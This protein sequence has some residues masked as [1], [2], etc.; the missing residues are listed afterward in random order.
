MP[1]CPI[2]VTHRFSTTDAQ[3]PSYAVGAP[4]EHPNELQRVR[5]E[6][7]Q[8][9]VK[10][11]TPEFLKTYAPDSFA[12]IMAKYG[13]YGASLDKVGIRGELLKTIGN[14]MFTTFPAIRDVIYNYIN[15]SWA[16]F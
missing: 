7:A 12:R 8:Q 14:H 9:G 3:R 13:E 15:K 6:I 4:I 1:C 5:K 10:K 16:N 11:V 2:S